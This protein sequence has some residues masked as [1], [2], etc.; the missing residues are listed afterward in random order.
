MKKIIVAIWLVGSTYANAYDIFGGIQTGMGGTALLST[1]VATGLLYC[2]SG[3]ID[4]G[5]LVIE[6]GW[7]R[8][9]EL[10]DL[11]RVF[12]SAGYRYGD[13]TGVI[14]FSQMGKSDYYTEKIVKFNLAYQTGIYSAGL[15]TSG[16][17][18]EIG[19]DIDRLQAA[20]I[21]LCAGVH[22]RRYHVAIV[23][24][25][26]NKPKIVES[27]EGENIKYNIYA[28]IDGGSMHSITGRVILEKY[29][30]PRVSLGQYIQLA[31][32]NSLFWGIS[33]NP[34]IYGGGLKIKYKEAWLAYAVSYH[35]SLGFTHNVSIAYSMSGILTGE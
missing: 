19:T 2:P 26:I 5:Q 3:H 20:S 14:G 11:D 28:E 7:N 35:P 16:R 18:V 22:Y 17:I 24:D 13:L 23:V 8:K 21:G 31:E 6:S 33:H 30:K 27:L 4:D 9:F 32:S 1:S 15:I 12:I 25:D 29:E 34:L 10:S